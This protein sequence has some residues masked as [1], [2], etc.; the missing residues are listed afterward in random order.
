MSSRLCSVPC[1]VDFVHNATYMPHRKAL[2]SSW[3]VRR[4]H[5]IQ[6]LWIARKITQTCSVH[7]KIVSKILGYGWKKT[8]SNW[9]MIRLKPFVSQHH[10]L[11]AR[12]CHTHR[13]SCICDPVCVCVR[14]CVRV[15]ACACVCVRAR[16]RLYVCVF[17]MLWM[18]MFVNFRMFGTLVYHWFV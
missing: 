17:P 2:Y 8:N 16:T 18:K 13:K 15:C 11:S 14:A 1:T 4:R 6:S 7:F 10:P 3:N 9:I 12:P 5:A